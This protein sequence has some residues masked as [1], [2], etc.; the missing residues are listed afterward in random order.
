MIYEIELHYLTA[1]YWL[2]KFTRLNNEHL[3]K[4]NFKL[5][6]EYKHILDMST[7][8]E[9]EDASGGWAGGHPQ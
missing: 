9:I 5:K 6:E 7:E 3:L 1:L 4:E 8:V 2:V